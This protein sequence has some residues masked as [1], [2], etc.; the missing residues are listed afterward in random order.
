MPS[1]CLRI[2]VAGAIIFSS[3]LIKTQRISVRE[4]E[5]LDRIAVIVWVENLN[6]IVAVDGAAVENSKSGVNR[7][8]TS[9]G[10][11]ELMVLDYNRAILHL[12]MLFESGHCYFPRQKLV[13]T[14][15]TTTKYVPSARSGREANYAP[16]EP[17]RFVDLT[18]EEADD[19]LSR[20][21]RK[22][23]GR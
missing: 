11:H 13:E 18:R 8:E 1:S 14:S 21:A 7:L 23:C 3:C 15:A 12:D 20:D 4:G 5:A 19:D 2:G 6:R 10:K 22:Y 16:I 17:L 9:A